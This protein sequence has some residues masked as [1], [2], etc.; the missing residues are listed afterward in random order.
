MRLSFVTLR[1]YRLHRE[2]RVGFDPSRTLIGGQNEAGKSTLVEAV[3]RALFLKAKGFRR[4]WRHV[5]PQEALWPG[6]HNHLGAVQRRAA[7]R[8]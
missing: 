6:R 3:H 7:F 4:K 2:V 8:G 5:S 1:N